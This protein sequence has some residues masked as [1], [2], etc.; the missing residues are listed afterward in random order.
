MKSSIRRFADQ[1]IAVTALA[2]MS[3]Q[4]TLAALLNLAQTPLFIGANVPPQ[5]MLT[6]SKDQ[7]L[8]KK[9]YND[10]SDLD[11]DGAI[12][13]TYKH[14]IDYY[15]YF[16]PAKCYDYSAANQRFEPVSVS[17]TKYCTGQWSGNFLNWVSMS[18]MDAVRKLLYGGMRATDNGTTTVLE[19]AY[20]PMDAHAWA[21]YYNGNDIAQL[22]PFNPPTTT[23]T[24]AATTAPISTCFGGW[25]YNN[26]PFYTPPYNM[27]PCPETG[28]PLRQVSA[29]DP[30]LDID[31]PFTVAM[32]G[33]MAVGDQI[34]VESALWPGNYL[35]GA[36][37]SFSNANRTVRVRVNVAGTVGWAAEF[38][39][40]VTNLSRTGISFCNLTTG[41]GA[42]ANALSQTNSNPPLIRVAQG[43]FQLWNANERYQCYW[44]GERSN[45]QSGF[46]G[47]RSNGNQASLSEIHASAENPSQA[48]NGLGTGSA[49]GEYIVRVQ[50]CVTGLFGT[51][52][53]K[54]YPNGNY[55]PIG[56]LQE[57]GDVNLIHFGLMTGS[58]R[59][60]ISGGVLRKNV[61]SFANEVNVA[62]D[63]TFTT[64]AVPPASPRA[65]NSAETPAGIVNTLNYM[66]IW[67]YRYANGDYLTAGGDN[68]TYQLTNITEDNCTSWGNPMS[69]IYFESLRYFAGQAASAAYTYTNS[70]SKDNQLGLPLPAVV[71]PLSAANYCAPLNV[72]VFNASVSTNDDDLRTT[73]ATAINTT[74]TAEALT[75]AVG[76]AEGITGNSYFVGKIIGSGA[77]LATDT[78]FELCTP[79]AIPGLGQVSGICPEGPTLAGSFLVAGLAHHARTNRIRAD[80]AGIPGTDTRSL[81]VTT[82]GIQ[83]ATNVPQLTIPVPG[84]ATGQKVIIQPIY[85]LVV[86]AARGGGALVDM[87][88]VRQEVVG[89]IARGKVYINWEDSEQGGDYDQ[90]MWGTLDW[91]LDA[92]ANT[93][94]IT[95][96]AVSASTANGQGFG[97]TISG[98]TMD[99]PHFHSG[100]LGFN[101]TDPTG[102]LGCTNCQVSSASSGQRGPQSVT[103]T[104]GTTT[105]NTL[106]DPL[107]YAAKY[108]AF[109]DGNGNG[110]PDVQS[111]W[112]SKLASG[113]PGQDGVPDNYFLVTNPLGLEAALDRAFITILANASASSV[114]TNSTS[115]QT[116]STIYQARFNSN[117]WSGQM[118]AYAVNLDGSIS[119]SPV[120]DAGQVVNGQNHDTGRVILTYNTDS[121]V[122]DGV[123][124]RWPANP[125]SPLPGE[126]PL[127][128]VNQLNV[129]PTTS[130]ADGRGAQRLGWLRGDASQ[131]GATVTSFRQRPTSKL[132]D[133]VNSNPNF[134]GAPAAGV[135]EAAY[136]QF[137]LTYLNRSPMI[138]VGGNDGMLHGFRAS[139]GRELL[140]YVPSK[141][142]G[143]LNQLTSRTYVHRYFVDGS[144][145]VGDA[146]I[147]AFWRTVLVG[148]LG[149][150]GQG[151]FA[152]DVTDPAQ[153]S[154]ANAASTVLWE[155][156]DTDDPDFGYVMG[157][158]AIRKMANGR[159]AA[160][161]AGGYNNSEVLPGET[162]C[163]DSTAKLPAGC[164]TSST[165]S[166]YL[167]V[168]FLEGPTGPNR[169]WVEGTDY[170]KIRAQ[171]MSD[172]T[173]TPNGLSEPFPADVN[174]DGVVDFVYAGDLR[175]RLWKFD[176]RSG[177]VANWTAAANRV[178]L[179]IARDGLGNRQ[180]ITS[181]PEGTL[182]SSGAGYMITFG[183]GKYL[184]P[185]DPMG[186]YLEQ[187]FY[188]IWDKND[189]ATVSVQ[190]TVTDR[191]QLL[192]Q[193]I[194]DVLV[195][196][197]TFR[198]V[199]NSAP[200]W[201]QDTTPPVA[202]DSPARHMGWYMAFPNAT[203]TGERS[204][205]RPILT[206]GRL[207]FTTLIPSTQACLFGGTS[208][209]MVIDPTSG[210]RI[211]GAVL[212]A[213]GNGILN[214]SDTTVLGGVN[215]YLSGVQSAIGI[216]PTPTI[217]KS[218]SGSGGGISGTGSVILGTTGPVLAGGGI[219]LAYAIAAGSSGANAS[220]IVG[221]S[222]GGGRVSWRELQQE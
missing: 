206:S 212:D 76:S 113:V 81:K 44:S 7:Q 57:Y 167:Y 46:G 180:P 190:T 91:V 75:N 122:R 116:G 32:N 138:Y 24:V 23:T 100:I 25:V 66:R 181:K 125:A 203:T 83:L 211:D 29:S 86:G 117:D 192:Q 10:Y 159:W 65:T 219:Q 93:I 109:V 13:T 188:G 40:N 182:H 149:S 175:G 143:Q 51:E 193:T 26:L 85:R 104:L 84:S 74:S 115:L 168:I 209:M 157:Y 43:N 194:T 102:V 11:G 58:H 216:T 186:P 12:E 101:Y 82:Y 68:C 22:T 130:V 173:G 120:W 55:K 49:Q 189:G 18:R 196:T 106:K 61:G 56:L 135:G 184:E 38:S 36:V 214:S 185:S 152:L 183:T 121:T 5:V 158:P 204:V 17:A 136:A 155:F 132:G 177:T 137:R 37:M 210:A 59:K 103:Y 178:V 96:N 179:H 164:T 221:L 147:G 90:D 162:A 129:S 198:V 215:V 200:T 54:Q 126:I 3:T 33:A 208:F 187:A 20:L 53:C 191:T 62:T 123:P 50:A 77:T 39:W 141:V 15:G 201:S 169:T 205:F 16:D 150:G 41:A 124:F 163:T 195:G 63:G 207:I 145:Q 140:A 27:P 199:S 4:P 160:I 166:A 2:C 30:S 6:V 97:Y 105:A 170:V 94:T 197:S 1:T 79:K 80:I 9:A 133:I 107:W 174:A 161:V 31:I 70:G 45:L 72:L 114:A 95:T 35:I 139:D 218:A 156:N 171:R 220:T 112:D 202:D 28:T 14:S 19:R 127:A 67:G 64:P 172:S 34:K 73:A 128:L 165:G 153:F 92:G 88:F 111:E 108:G 131:E 119:T 217:I 154:E 78:G 48:A 21:K 176:L 144:P 71:D 98:T 142:H 222:S 148:G 47:V 42:A 213:D 118:L 52:R 146:Y 134:V 87:K 60:N 151:L 8:Y 89:S 99:G 110:L 69:E